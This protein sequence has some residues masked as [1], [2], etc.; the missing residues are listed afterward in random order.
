MGAQT[1]SCFSWKAFSIGSGSVQK[2]KKSK[3]K[4]AQH[5]LQLLQKPD[6]NCQREKGSSHNH[7][8]QSLDGASKRKGTLKTQKPSVSLMKKTP[9]P[10][11]N[12]VGHVVKSGNNE[13]K[14]LH[15][16]AAVFGYCSVSFNSDWPLKSQSECSEWS[17]RRSETERS[18]GSK[19]IIQHFASTQ[20]R[21]SIFLQWVSTLCAVSVLYLAINPTSR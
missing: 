13:C 16:K 1:L 2:S 20:S 9:R 19:M 7:S 11:C 6:Q 14:Y 3:T 17:R 18:L 21:H 10:I 5:T 12:R 4:R 8:R 15:T